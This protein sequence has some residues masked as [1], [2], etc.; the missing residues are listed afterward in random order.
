MWQAFVF[1]GGG[2]GVARGV[3][4]EWVWEEFR[5]AASVMYRNRKVSCHRYLHHRHS[6]CPN[7]FLAPQM[8]VKSP[9]I[10]DA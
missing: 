1:R 8:S 3:G 10:H 6:S 2:S 7:L 9:G 5:T 4:K